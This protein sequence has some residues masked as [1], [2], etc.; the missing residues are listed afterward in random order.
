MNKPEQNGMIQEG[1]NELDHRF[2][3]TSPSHNLSSAA[4]CC[5]TTSCFGATGS[6]QSHVSEIILFIKT[7]WP[8]QQLYIQ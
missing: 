6:K 3:A 8:N 7:K 5:I 2:L 1:Q 4:V